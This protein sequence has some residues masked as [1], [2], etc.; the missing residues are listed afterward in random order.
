MSL[1][2]SLIAR[3]PL[4]VSYAEC[5]GSFNAIIAKPWRGVP[6]VFYYGK[7]D[8]AAIVTRTYHAARKHCGLDAS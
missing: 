7:W 5:P 2:Q 8:A 3:A 6:R 4:G 1:E